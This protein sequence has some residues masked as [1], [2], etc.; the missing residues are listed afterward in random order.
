MK[1]ASE[2]KI[3]AIAL[4]VFVAFTTITHAVAVRSPQRVLNAGTVAKTEFNSV[5]A[6]PPEYY[7]LLVAGGDFGLYLYFTYQCMGGPGDQT[8]GQAEDYYVVRASPPFT[9][10]PESPDTVTLVQDLP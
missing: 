7:W 1:I 2:R 9:S 4:V 6:Q 8:A 3:V 5:T 10:T